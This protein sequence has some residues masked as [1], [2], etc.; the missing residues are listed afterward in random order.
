MSAIP[1]DGSALDAPRRYSLSIGR[2]QRAVLWFFV[3]CGSI[4]VIEPSPYEFMFL[5]AVFV[6]L[7]TGIRINRKV[8]PL[9]VLLLLFNIGGV[10]SLIPFM[11]ERDSVRFIAVGVYLMFTAILFAALMC[12]D[13]E[14][15]LRTILS[16]Y[17]AGAWIAATAGIIGYFNIAG[18]GESLTLWGR[19]SGTFK[20]PNVMGPF[21]VLPIVFLAQMI[22]VGK[23][24]LVRGVA[25]MSV[26]VLG[27]FLTFSRGAWGNLVL[28]VCVVFALTF[29][30]ADTARQRARVVGFALLILAF[31]I[32]ALAVALSFEAIREVFLVRASLDQYYDVGVQ[33]RFGNQ[34][35]S[36]NMLIEMPNGMGPLRFRY[37]FPDD[38]HNT[39]INAFA[40][41]GWLGGFSFVGLFVATMIAGWQL[42]FR[43]SALQAY[44]IPIWA[45]TFVVL[46]QG[47]QIDIDHWRHLYLLLGLV[48]GLRAVAPER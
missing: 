36:I 30:T 43:R 4:A 18:L 9:V 13:T 40:S 17:I 16:G 35:R 20:D 25:L 31:A 12:E 11:D 41:Y 22:L 32:A 34:L 26:P 23:I 14:G 6:F 46:L 45:T 21:L 1:Q 24:G 3:A 39:F 5:V 2:L 47:I 15:R 42:V 27:L 37:Y 19:A 7:I 38:P 8:L 29:L 48:W 10:I 33:G 28:T 44:A